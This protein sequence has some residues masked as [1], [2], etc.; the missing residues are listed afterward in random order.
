MDH[1]KEWD[2]E[3][4]GTGPDIWLE[5]SVTTTLQAMIILFLYY[6]FLHL[7]SDPYITR[8]VHIN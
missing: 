8:V 3:W 4:D 1:R 5:T 2:L 7:F 6:T